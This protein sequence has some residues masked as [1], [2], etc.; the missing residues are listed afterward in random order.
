[1]DDTTQI[2]QPPSPNN[3]QFG[4]AGTF[5]RLAAVTVDSLLIT[6]IASSLGYTFS[7]STKGAFTSNSFAFPTFILTIAYYLFFWV[8]ENGQTLGKRFMGIRI[9]RV[10]NQPLDSST[11][12]IRYIGYFVSSLVFCLGYLWAIFDP[13][14]QAWHDKMAKTIVV[15]VDANKR[16]GRMVLMSLILFLIP[17]IISLL[18]ALGIAAAILAPK[19]VKNPQLTEAFKQALPTSTVVDAA[20][21][22]DEVFPKVNEQRLTTKLLPLTLDNHLCAYAQRR[23]E[24]LK[25][26]GKY[27]DGKGFYEDMANKEINNAYFSDYGTV[28]EL[29][30]NLSPITQSDELLNAWRQGKNN[31]LSDQKANNACVRSN[32]ETLILISGNKIK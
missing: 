9:V 2:P 10:D 17:L 11:A 30:Y 22:E 5:R 19:L 14:K 6:L 13:Q 15:N 27:D 12:V 32:G 20:V 4:Y 7:S 18:F 28:A 3:H 21:F 23:L 8:K 16:T 29:T 26:F 25:A 24:Q 1:M 31:V